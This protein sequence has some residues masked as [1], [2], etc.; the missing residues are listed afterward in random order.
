M[1]PLYIYHHLGM[2]DAF[3]CNGLV[4]HY[5]KLYKKIVVFAKPHFVDNVSRMYKDNPNISIKGMDDQDI[6]YWMQTLGKFEKIKLVGHTSDYILHV[7][8][9]KDTKFNTMY[10]VQHNL[11]PEIQWE[12]FYIER[13]LEKEKYVFENIFKLDED[14][15]FLFVHEDASRFRRFKDEYVNRNIKIINSL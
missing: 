15:E 4:R 3:L 2:G 11:D 7:D 9:M 6:R 1:S 8:Q 5:Q 12:E 14:E 10:Y 13:D